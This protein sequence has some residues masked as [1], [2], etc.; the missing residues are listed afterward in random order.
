MGG[1]NRAPTCS[2]A[3]RG[4]SCFATSLN[5]SAKTGMV[6]DND[7]LQEREGRGEGEVGKRERWSGLV[8]IWLAG[9]I[10]VPDGYPSADFH[11][12]KL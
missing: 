11:Q 9:V 5:N 6:D 2:A 7:W 8:F 3:A 10:G 12:I 4:A 1:D